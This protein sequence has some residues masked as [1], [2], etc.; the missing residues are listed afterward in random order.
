MRATAAE[1]AERLRPRWLSV[2]LGGAAS[3]AVP[4]LYA[5]WIRQPHL[6]YDDFNFL[7][8]SRTW[9]E[10]AANLWLPMN[11]HAMPLPRLA[12]AVLMHVVP[13][14]SSIPLAAQ[15][16]GSF[17]VVIGMW[18]LYVFVRRELGH[19]WYAYLA[20][21]GWGVTAAFYE[22][23]TWYSAS[24]FVFSLDTTILAL[25]AA[26]AWR[27]SGSRLALAGCVLCCALAP[28][29]YGGGILAGLYCAVYLLAARAFEKTG[30]V[31]R[32]RVSALAPLAGTLLFLAVSLPLTASRIVTAEHYGGKTVFE[33]F[34]LRLGVENTLRT[35]ADNQVIGA[36]GIYRTTAFA[37]PTV[38]AIDLALLALAFAWW[39][40]A[41]RRELLLLGLV[42]I[43]AS[44]L[45]VYSARADWDY[46]RTVHRWTRYHLF[47]HLGLVLFAVGGL[48][49]LNGR[50][51]H[52]QP[53]RLSGWQTAALLTVL[54]AALACHLPRSRIRHIYFPEQIDVLARVEHVDAL[55]RR[56][57]I[58]ASTAREAMGFLQ[59][60]FGYDGDNAWEF[61]RG[62]ATPIA[63]PAEQARAILTR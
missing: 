45:L 11:D 60:P 20:M 29:W 31:M 13:G 6:R 37:P 15:L 23:V 17:A 12:A 41:P 35:I 51:F 61:L 24:F 18:L 7:T 40:R 52:L 54:G 50:W 48:P 38:I 42:L 53:G 16:Q 33:A 26:Q 32:S 9:S 57:H 2:G 1:P 44:D 19:P 56:H 10:A 3:L 39:R 21:I 8:R 30:M 36:F 14:Q 49:W 4:A 63:M 43:V 25:L 5:I 46:E 55:C 22:C 28:A 47:P 58:S 34:N 27:R 59:F 62:S